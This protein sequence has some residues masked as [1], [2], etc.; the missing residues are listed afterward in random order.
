MKK[1]NISFLLAATLA[2][3]CMNSSFAND[4][5]LEAMQKSIEAVYHATS[6]EQYQHE[7]NTLQR[8]A[9]AEPKRWEPAY[10]TGFC[11][12]MMANLEADVLKKDRYLD[13]AMVSIQRAK[14]IAGEESEVLTLEGFVYMMRVSVDPGARG[15]EFAPLAMQTFGSAVQAN[16]ENPRALTLM[17]RMQYGTAEF[18]G[19][20]T[21]EACENVN[22]ARLKFETYK[23]NNALAPQWGKGIAESLMQKCK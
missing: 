5:Y 8:I 15:P 12:L 19:S 21:T 2:V 20:S 10:Y 17:A 3:G 18:F 22:K 11:Y 23:S 4:Q 13:E 9:A 16:P 14:D 7:I 1:L 6:I